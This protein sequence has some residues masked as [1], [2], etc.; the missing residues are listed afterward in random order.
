MV[1]EVS[2]YHPPCTNP[3]LCAPG[4]TPRCSPL[5]VEEEAPG[6]ASLRGHPRHL[7]A[8]APPGWKEPFSGRRPKAR[9]E[10]RSDSFPS[11]RIPF[12]RAVQPQR[13][14][15]IQLGQQPPRSLGRSRPSKSRLWRDSAIHAEDGYHL[16]TE[17][18]VNNPQSQS[19]RQPLYRKYL[20]TGANSRWTGPGGPSTGP[21]EAPA[22]IQ[23][24]G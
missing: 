1:L 5:P 16:F 15:D 8:P 6:R 21:A 14:Q 19:N 7:P 18:I 22:R 2:V 23:P 10:E 12:D 3:T 4:Q 20:L 13:R 11:L 24:S 9:R 17:K